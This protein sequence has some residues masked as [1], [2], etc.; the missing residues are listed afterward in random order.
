MTGIF[1]AQKDPSLTAN[2]VILIPLGFARTC[3]LQPLPSPDLAHSL[4]VH[5]LTLITGSSMIRQ[6]LQNREE[7]THCLPILT[8]LLLFFMIIL[9]N[10]ISTNN[11]LVY[12]Q[13][14]RSLVSYTPFLTYLLPTFSQQSD[15][16]I[17]MPAITLY[18][19]LYISLSSA[20]TPCT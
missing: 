15:I 12:L 5:P 20:P 8:K 1:C 13:S 10:T 7:F 3:R 6:I 18:V 17:L 4:H 9:A 16:S 19:S 11:R 2:N 14:L